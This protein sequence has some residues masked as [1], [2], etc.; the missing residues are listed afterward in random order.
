MY[1]DEMK[2]AFHSVRPPDGFKG[3]ELIDNEHFLSIRLDEN[4]FA[5]L[6]EEDKRRAIQ[7]VFTLKK[8]LEDSGAVVLVVRKALGDK[9]VR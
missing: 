6:V 7:Y 1:T 2:K 5:S 4:N 3:V 8:A 9:D